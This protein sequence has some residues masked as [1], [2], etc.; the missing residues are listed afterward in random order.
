MNALKA[1]CAPDVLCG[2]HYNIKRNLLGFTEWGINR[3]GGISVAICRVG[4]PYTH[5]T[6][7]PPNRTRFS[8]E[9]CVCVA[10][11][12]SY[13]RRRPY[14]IRTSLFESIQNFCAVRIKN[15][16]GVVQQ[17][18]WRKK[19]ERTRERKSIF[20]FFVYIHIFYYLKLNFYLHI[21]NYFVSSDLLRHIHRQWR[22]LNKC[23]EEICF[24]ENFFRFYFFLLLFLLFNIINRANSPWRDLKVCCMKIM[25][26]RR[27]KYIWY[28]IHLLA[29]IFRRLVRSM[30]W[31]PKI[32][33][34]FMEC[35]SI[36]LNAVLRSQFTI[37]HAL[38]VISFYV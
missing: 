33:I 21:Q 29:H 26:R 34:H 2:A 12:I 17:I 15:W 5:C 28:L 13:H 19:S 24:I 7:I 18:A 8:I 22:R 36:G 31:I 4:G 20:S 16:F 10:H 35:K 9:D 32:R 38:N 25:L 3:C 37:D 27:A 14:N 30:P 23:H 11:Y 1:I 6:R